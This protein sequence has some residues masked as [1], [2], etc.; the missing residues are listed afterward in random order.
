V[1]PLSLNKK[2]A[3]AGVYLA[4]LTFC[5]SNYY[6]GWHLMGPL[7]KGILAIATLIGAICAHR[8]GPALIEELWE[9]RTSK[10]RGS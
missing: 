7:D 10:R 1:T 6:L 9:Y 8:Y 3:L 2:R 4:G 5:A